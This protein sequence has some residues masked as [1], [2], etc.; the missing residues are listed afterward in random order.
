MTSFAILFSYSCFTS[1]FSAIVGATFFRF[2]RIRHQLSIPGRRGEWRLNA[3]REQFQ[4]KFEIV[5]P[6][7]AEKR[8]ETQ[9]YV[10]QMA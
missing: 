2:I 4:M 6:T 3:D 1:R 10:E 8:D 5:A 7:I 9:E